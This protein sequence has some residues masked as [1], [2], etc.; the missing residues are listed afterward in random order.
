M[1]ALKV[2]HIP[3]NELCSVNLILPIGQVNDPTGQIGITHLI[4]H[5]FFHAH[6]Y[7]SQEQM[8]IKIEEMGGIVNAITDREMTIIYGKIQKKYVND[9]LNL[10]KEV[11]LNLE[12]SIKYIETER[13][14]ILQEIQNAVLKPYHHM[15]DIQHQELF[16]S[17]PFQQNQYVTNDVKTITAEDV[18]AFLK[19][20]E[21]KYWKVLIV[22]G[23]TEKEIDPSL[24]IKG[25]ATIVQTP[26]LSPLKT[27]YS[28]EH[29]G[30]HS[31]ITVSVL[32]PEHFNDIESIIVTNILF[33]GISSP[34]YSE[35][36]KTNG[37]TYN[38]EKTV[39]SYQNNKYLE[40]GWR[41]QK[42]DVERSQTLLNGLIDKVLNNKINIEN[43]VD[44]GIQ[45]TKTE[46]LLIQENFIR[47]SS[48]VT[49][50]IA[51]HTYLNNKLDEEINSASKNIVSYTQNLFEQPILFGFHK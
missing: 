26:I 3:H 39:H 1:E 15:C 2:I 9:L 12:N 29:E 37:I 35:I 6:P 46:I 13:A 10:F 43:Y 28:Y 41:C 50:Q 16:K 5:L 14:I 7:L 27:S 23:I 47:H 32:L 21:W 51:L 19:N 49:K 11:I 33:N 20:Y 45:K 22:G 48:H 36:V 30:K 8:M 42:H 24:E 17:H 18:Q 31:G 4:E 44:S 25:E 34:F 38:I 40:F